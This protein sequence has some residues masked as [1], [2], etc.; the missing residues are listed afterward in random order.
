M[1]TDTDPHRAPGFCPNCDSPLGGNFCQTCGQ[2]ARLHVPSA[3]EF[4]HEFIA[5]YVALEGK[6]WKSLGMLLFKPGRLTREYIEGR[7]VPYVEPLRLYLSF[8]I[9]FFAIYKFGD[10]RWRSSTAPRARRRRRKRQ[11]RASR[12]WKRRAAAAPADPAV[13]TAD[14]RN[15]VL[16]E[17]DKLNPTLGSKLRQFMALPRT[18]KDAAV[19]KAFFSYTPYAIFALMPLF[20]AYLKLLYLGSG[21]RYGEHLLFALHTNAFAFLAL[22]LLLILPSGIPLVGT[23]LTLWLMFYTPTAMRR[24]YGGGRLMT[25]LRWIAL[26]TLH[27]FSMVLA[28]VAVTALGAL[29]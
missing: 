20:A 9:I 26:M 15:E 29:A 7:R 1:N 25:G 21:R 13:T 14:G 5:H 27:F 3:R 10:Y 22:S 17:V 19:R 12:R 24:V 18:D 11:R 28:V 23:A 8:S 4:L 2:P 6:L 16:D